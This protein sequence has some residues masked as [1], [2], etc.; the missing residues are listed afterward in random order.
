M[1]LE[2][3]TFIVGAFQ[4]N[5]YVVWSQTARQALV[6]D[7]GAEPAAIKTFLEEKNLQ[8]TRYLL[9]HGHVDHLG[10]LQAL[11]N[12]FPAA[13]IMHPADADWAFKATNSIQPYYAP[14]MP[15]PEGTV[16]PADLQL[17][18]AL[19]ECQ[20]FHTPGHSPGSVCYYFPATEALFTG[21]TLF[22]GT[23]GRTDLPG[24]STKTLSLSLQSL[25]GLPLQ[26]RV[27]AGHGEP[28][29]MEN[30]YRYNPFLAT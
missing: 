9:T 28:S 26:T 17:K 6:I 1:K 18:T 24:G 7:P 25:K 8:L 14:P 16:F 2:I 29:T 5:C 3:E 27:Y 19:G 22:K 21:D 15:P 30:E 12:I 23:V 10:G 4:V 13:V 11:L 20:I